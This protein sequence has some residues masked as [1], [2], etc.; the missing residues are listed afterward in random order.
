M[1]GWHRQSQHK[2][3]TNVVIKLIYIYIYIYIYRQKSSLHYEK[4]EDDPIEL[5]HAQIH[6]AFH[7][8]G[9]LHYMKTN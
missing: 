7:L 9:R 2:F 5:Y 3:L 1:F 8:C 4:F 6:L